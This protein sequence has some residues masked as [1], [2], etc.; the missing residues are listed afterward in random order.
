M[1]KGK[2][3][4]ENYDHL[5]NLIFIFCEVGESLFFSTGY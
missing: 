1:K 3:D 2:S 5:Q 4:Q